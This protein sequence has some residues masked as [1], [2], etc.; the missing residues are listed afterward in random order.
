VIVVFL[1]VHSEFSLADTFIELGM[2]PGPHLPVVIGRAVGLTKAL[3]QAVASLRQSMPRPYEPMFGACGGLETTRRQ[4]CGASAVSREL[5]T[6][7][8]Y[9]A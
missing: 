7:S 3:F 8:D 9:C 4:L 6:P 1:D 5:P 2:V